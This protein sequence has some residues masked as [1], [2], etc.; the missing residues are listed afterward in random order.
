MTPTRV[1]K[2]CGTRTSKLLLLTGAV[3]LVLGSGSALAAEVGDTTLDIYGFAMLD[4]G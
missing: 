1:D 2:A 4:T 3:A